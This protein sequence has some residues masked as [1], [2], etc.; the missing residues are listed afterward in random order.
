MILS[1]TLQIMGRRESQ[2]DAVAQVA[3]P[4]GQL[5]VLADGMGGHDAGEVA[6][7]KAVQTF[8]DYFAHP[9]AGEPI[10]EA[11]ANALNRAN[12]AIY[13]I[14]VQEKQL[15]GM[16]TTLLAVHVNQDSGRFDY[17]S[18]GDSPLYH[19]DTVSGSMKRINANH[20]YSETL[21]QMVAAGEISEQDAAQ[22][23]KRHAITS[24]LTG[25]NIPQIDQASGSLKHGER[26]LLASDGVQI[27]NDAQIQNIITRNNMV[28]M[29]N[30]ALLGEVE[31]QAYAYQDNASSILVEFAATVAVREL[32]SPQTLIRP[33]DDDNPLFRQPENASEMRSVVIWGSVLL[34][35][36]LLVAYL[37]I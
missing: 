22:H 2:Q 17:I 28:E 8:V 25:E 13:A 31:A 32:A 26:L 27:L 10:G 4:N 3:V 1:H 5:F 30:Q 24:A 21:A 11:L 29:V 20:A 36:M 19:C 23:P 6:S 12:A 16:G 34:V 9:I 35:L 18:V 37:L 15:Y 7:Q 33:D 14:I